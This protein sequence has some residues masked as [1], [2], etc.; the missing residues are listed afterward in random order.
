LVFLLAFLSV[1]AIGGG[2]TLII[3]PKGELMQLPLELIE[4]SLFSNYL[5]PG[6][7]LF[8]FFGLLPPIVIAGLLGNRKCKIAERLNICNDMNWSWTFTVYIGFAIIIWIQ[9]QISIIKSIHWFHTFYVFLGIVILATAM[10]SPMRHLY[11]TGK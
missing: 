5:I 9:V 8:I 1:G 7:I 11:K 10:L 2:V 6:L 4:G 3:S